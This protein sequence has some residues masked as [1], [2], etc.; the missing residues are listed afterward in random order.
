MFLK[1][2]NL[3]DEHMGRQTFLGDCFSRLHHYLKTYTLPFRIVVQGLLNMHSGKSVEKNKHAV[4]NKRAG[5]IF[6]NLEIINNFVLS[7]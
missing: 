4:S 5:W 1:I 7:A 2:S 3:R 6:S